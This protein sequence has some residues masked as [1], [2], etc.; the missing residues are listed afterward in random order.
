METLLNRPAEMIEQEISAALEANDQEQLQA[1]VRAARP[2]DLAEVLER[3]NSD[4]EL[5]VFR[6]AP[7]I[8]SLIR[9]TKW[10]AMLFG[11]FLVIFRIWKSLVF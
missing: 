7:P 11:R 6:P 10:A 8:R 2:A 5:K 4:D 1:L 3:L 9:F